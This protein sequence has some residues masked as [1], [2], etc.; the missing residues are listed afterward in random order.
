[1][2]TER[3]LAAQ[4]VA[5]SVGRN[6]GWNGALTGAGW[7]GGLALGSVAAI[8]GDFEAGAVAVGFAVSTMFTIEDL[9]VD[10]RVPV[11]A[12]RT[13]SFQAS[14]GIYEV[15]LSDPGA[16]RSRDARVVQGVVR[17]FPGPMVSG[18]YVDGPLDAL[19]VV[20]YA[21]TGAVLYDIPVGEPHRVL[22]RARCLADGSIRRRSDRHSSPFRCTD[23]L[24]VAGTTLAAAA[25]FNRLRRRSHELMDRQ[26]NCRRFDTE[27]VVEALSSR[28]NSVTDSDELAC[29]LSAMLESA[30]APA[31]IEI[32]IRE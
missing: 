11:D 5:P 32:W 2:D 23:D 10:L 16:S 6:L 12:V 28:I 31:S 27:R 24:A 4:D 14:L 26:F 18:V 22:R 13:V 29:D 15:H 17:D 1:M 19:I 8:L 30:L 25:L 9:G 7:G 3:R 21:V 20:A